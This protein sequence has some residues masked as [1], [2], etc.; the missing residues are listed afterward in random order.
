MA[1]LP[2]GLQI[3]PRHWQM[4]QHILAKYLPGLEVWAFG[5]R[6][7]GSAKPHSDLDLAVIAQQPLSLQVQAAL[8][9]AFSESELPWR[10]DVVD[11]ATTPE[12][13]RRVIAEHKVIVQTA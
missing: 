3:E 10:V 6:T 8:A 9:E 4:V 13:F 12:S 5:S 7:K 11:W 2:E 1:D